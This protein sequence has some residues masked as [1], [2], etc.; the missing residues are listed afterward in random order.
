MIHPASFPPY[1][2]FLLIEYCKFNFKPFDNKVSFQLMEVEGQ[3]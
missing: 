3:C 1:V 2:I